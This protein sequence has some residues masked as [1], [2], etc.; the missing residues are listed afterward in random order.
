M[1]ILIDFQRDEGATKYDDFAYVDDTYFE[2]VFDV[3]LHNLGATFNP[4]YPVQLGQTF[5]KADGTTATQGLWYSTQGCCTL[6]IEVDDKEQGKL[7][8]NK[9]TK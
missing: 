1:L 6:H 4:F 3:N 7:E 5:T 2:L 9:K 8:L